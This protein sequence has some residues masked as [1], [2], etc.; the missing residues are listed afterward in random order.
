MAVLTCVVILVLSLIAAAFHSHV[1]NETP[2]DAVSLTL[3][4]YPKVEGVYARN[5][6]LESAEKLG[7]GKILQPEDIVPDPTG[8]FLYV[9][10]LD[11][12]IK[13]L[14]LADNTVEDWKRVGGR[15]LGLA[16][17]NDGELLVC[18]PTQG[19]LKVT[20][21]E[22]SVLATEVNG[23]KLLLPDAVT[24]AKDG[25]IYLTDAT[26]KYSLD[27]HLHDTLEARPNGRIVVFDP[28]SK[29][30]HILLNDLYFPN[31]ITISRDDSYLLF[32]ETTTSRIRKHYLK[33]DRKGETETLIESLPGFPDNIHWSSKGDVLYV[34][35][36]GGP[37]DAVI[38][39]LWQSPFLKSLLALYPS[40][41]KLFDNSLKWAGVLA[42]DETGRPVKWL[43]DRS[44][45]TVA[46]VTTG[47][48]V[49]GFLYLGGLRD[50]FVGR[51][52]A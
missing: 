11:G 39:L 17:G 35:L 44:G 43:E 49:D 14:H 1:M 13:K 51:V 46:C 41:Q 30:T 10:T 7:E 23:T 5:N 50:G 25:L 28:A 15:P 2:I 52:A 47:V 18:E 3:A 21:D 42:I 34:G 24:V 22:I 20:E 9:S 32:A 48:E 16:V 4:P 6:L 33:G 19:L 29:S 40:L 12:W 8:K 36:V 27:L 45:K 37:R 38:D 31:G 26:T